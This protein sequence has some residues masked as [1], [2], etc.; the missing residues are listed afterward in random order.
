M[1]FERREKEKREKRESEKREI[2][3]KRRTY[4]ALSFILPFPWTHLL[5]VHGEKRSC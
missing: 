2:L 3:H 1:S 5:P 4:L